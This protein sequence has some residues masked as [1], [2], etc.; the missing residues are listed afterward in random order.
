MKIINT[1][2]I[3]ELRKQ[4]QEFKKNNQPVIV[5]AQDDDF[6]R[7]LFE[8]P[9]IDIVV[10]LEMH[11]RKDY[12]KQKDSGLNEILAN[13]AK[14]NNIK[15]GIDIDSIKSLSHLNK[16]ILLARIKQN[17]DLCKRTKT[18]IIIISELKKQDI[19]GLMLS[20]GANTYQAKESCQK[21]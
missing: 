13:L 15:I 16:A 9:D 5:R 10:G 14:K 18:Q 19:L 1:T 12:M 11:L 8:N 7:K 2:N 6:N 21:L 3:N 17:I 20:L 4:I